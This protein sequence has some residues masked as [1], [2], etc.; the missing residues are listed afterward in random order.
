MAKFTESIVEDA[1][2][3]WLEELNYPPDKQE[4]ASQTVPMQQPD[5]SAPIGPRS[6]ALQIRFPLPL[7][8]ENYEWF[9]A[10][11]FWLDSS[12]L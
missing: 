1:A 6:K 3:S 7:P 12:P 8:F 4:K 11:R 2:L 10:K 5:S 9:C